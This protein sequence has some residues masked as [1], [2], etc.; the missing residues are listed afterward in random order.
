MYGY[1]RDVLAEKGNA[2]HTVPVGATVRDAV[3]QMNASSVGS[4]VVMQLGQIVGIFTER[5]VLK[6]VVD[7]GLHPAVARVGEVMTSP[8]LTI[9]PGTR[10]TEAM[11]LMTGRR[12]RHLPVIA[13]GELVGMIS[14]G[15]LLRRVT[16]VQQEDIESM[17]D[18]ITGGQRV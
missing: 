14:I 9:D 2:V 4:L 6:R 5:D 18:Y 15:D 11:E 16:H 12:L 13:E 3:Q 10:I 8:V 1:V 7:P 17:T